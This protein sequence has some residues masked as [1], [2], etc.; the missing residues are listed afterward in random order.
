MIY[1]PNSLAY[2]YDE[3]PNYVNIVYEEDY[4]AIA[5]SAEGGIGVAYDISPKYH[6]SFEQFFQHAIM[7]FQNNRSSF[8]DYNGTLY[9][10]S[11]PRF[12]Y[13]PF[14]LGLRVSFFKNI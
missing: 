13:R 1:N 10:V 12:V 2:Q 8:L 5:V 6:V 3:D 14:F 4:K 9:S 11:E 7:E